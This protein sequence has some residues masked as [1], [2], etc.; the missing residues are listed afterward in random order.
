MANFFNSNLSFLFKVIFKSVGVVAAVLLLVNVA[1]YF[2]GL[3]STGFY[4]E[5]SSLF[6]QSAFSLEGRTLA[7]QINGQSILGLIIIATIV[8]FVHEMKEKRSGKSAISNMDKMARN[9]PVKE[10]SNRQK[11]YSKMSERAA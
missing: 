11:T 5:S 1:A 6:Q 9:T 10:I 4:A 2:S 8:V 7:D 3:V